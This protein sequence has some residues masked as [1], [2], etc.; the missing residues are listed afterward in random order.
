MFSV[1][2]DALSIGKLAVALPHSPNLNENG[3]NTNEAR[4]LA[5]DGRRYGQQRR[6]GQLGKP[7]RIGRRQQTGPE[8]LP[9][10][11]RPKRFDR[12]AGRETSGD[13]DSAEALCR[14]VTGPCRVPLH[15][16][17]KGIFRIGCCG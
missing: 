6:D 7:G 1:S 17:R 8:S 4:P 15:A 2:Q 5:V 16:Q 14:G 9:A 11:F 12:L 10:R 13:D 3:Q